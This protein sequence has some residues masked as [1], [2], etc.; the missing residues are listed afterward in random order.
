MALKDALKVSRKTFFNP[1]GWL[2]YDMLK[3]QFSTNWQ[4]IK[5]LYSPAETG[6]QE[7]FEQAKQRFNLT[8]Q[9][10]DQISRNFKLYILIF[11]TC[12][13]ITIL[14]SFYLLFFL[15]AFAG[16]I[17]GIVTS[18]VF[19]AF[20]FRYSFW[21]FEMKHRK[22]GCTFDEWLRGKPSSSEDTRH[23]D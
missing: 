16:F 15:G 3:T 20:A 5:N 9:Q 22:L 6:R 17:L 13:L 10:V 1:T 23:V 8:D 11:M 14:F 7:T 12:G 19:F 21:R 2:G 18:T 4:I